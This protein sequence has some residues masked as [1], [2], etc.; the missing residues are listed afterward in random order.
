MRHLTVPGKTVHRLSLVALCSAALLP[1]AAQPPTKSS[2]TRKASTW[3]ATKPI[4]LSAKPTPMA[5]VPVKKLHGAQPPAPWLV[6][7]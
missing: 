4:K 1:A 2:S 3:P 6:V 7:L 5:C